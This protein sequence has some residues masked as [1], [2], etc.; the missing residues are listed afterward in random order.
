[1]RH[2]HLKLLS[3][4]QNLLGTYTNLLTGGVALE[5]VFEVMDVSPEVMEAATPTSLPYVRQAVSFSKVS[6]RYAADVQVLRDVSFTI[7]AGQVCAVVGASGAGKSTLADLLLRFY[8][9]DPGV[10]SID[11]QDMRC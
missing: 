8:D 10:I 2:Y 3:P 5:R 6:F 11:G 4:V 1:M 9:P 7:P